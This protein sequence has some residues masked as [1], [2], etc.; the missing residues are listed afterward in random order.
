MMYISN[1]KFQ[2]QTVKSTCTRRH[3]RMKRIWSTLTK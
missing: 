2:W 3:K 1:T